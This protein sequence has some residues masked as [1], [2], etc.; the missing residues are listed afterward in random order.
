WITAISLLLICIAGLTIAVRSGNRSGMRS[1]HL[2]V[3]DHDGQLE[4]RWDPNSDLFRRTADVKL[5]ILDG[6]ERLIVSLNPAQLQRGTA[7]YARRSDRVEVSI[8]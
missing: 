1:I 2:E 3:R 8:T 4:I 5:S 6:T 7:L